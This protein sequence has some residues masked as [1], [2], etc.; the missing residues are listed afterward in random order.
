[1][2]NEQ[3]FWTFFFELYESIPRQ[4]PGSDASTLRALGALPPLDATHRILDIG[5][6]SG[7]QTMTLARN[8][9]AQIVASDFHAPFLETL[10]QR[11]SAA[12]V[13]H[14]ISTLQADMAALPFEPE[15]FDHLWAEG[16]VFIIGLERGL[17]L[18]RP[19]V[20]PGG[21]LVLSDLTVSPDGVPDEVREFCLEGSD[22][23]ATVAGRLRL[24]KEKGWEVV[25]TFP[26]PN[27]AW[28]ES[29]YTPLMAQVGPFE[30]RHRNEPEA[31]AVVQRCRHETDLFQRY[32]HLYGYTF[33]LLRRTT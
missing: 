4:G 15:E 14:R 7:A 20:K 28:W 22:V 17:E 1:M 3:L 30:Q 19:L 11:A 12:G 31:Q 26:L 8:C 32:G 33:F 10:M 29:F 24:I 2:S 6:G 5:C 27:S 13:A 25:E 21:F 9:P 18:W 16:S 23:D